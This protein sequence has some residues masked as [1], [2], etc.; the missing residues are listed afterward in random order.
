MASKAVACKQVSKEISL[1][2]ARA[3]YNKVPDSKIICCGST[4]MRRA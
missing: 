1:F 4:S 2:K 3:A